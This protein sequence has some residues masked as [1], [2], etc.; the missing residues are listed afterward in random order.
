MK[1]RKGGEGGRLKEAV[2]GVEQS[3]WTL[4][5]R[6]WTSDYELNVGMSTLVEQG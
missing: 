2:E 1:R 3:S 6:G 4:C 5:A